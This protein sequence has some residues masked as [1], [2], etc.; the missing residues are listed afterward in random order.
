MIHNIS[1]KIKSIFMTLTKD[2]LDTIIEHK[3]CFSGG[4]AY[5]I[6]SKLELLSVLE[7]TRPYFLL[8]LH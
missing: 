3:S 7:K 4:L 8:I 2:L 1:C 6:F 5:K